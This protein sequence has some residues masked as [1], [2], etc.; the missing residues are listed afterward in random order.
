MEVERHCAVI[1]NSIWEKSLPIFEV[2]HSLN[3]HLIGL[4]H[5][6]REYTKIDEKIFVVKETTLRKNLF[7]LNKITF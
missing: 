1:K 2:N 3:P 5:R 4:I 7:P 6:K